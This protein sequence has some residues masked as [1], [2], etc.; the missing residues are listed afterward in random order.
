[1]TLINSPTPRTSS[2]HNFSVAQIERKN[3]HF[4]SDTEYSTS[5][6][7]FLLNPSNT[8]AFMSR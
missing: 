7:F 5:F 2:I 4:N 8:A 6:E 1:M 3:L